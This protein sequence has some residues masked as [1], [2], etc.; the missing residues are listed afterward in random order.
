M[1]VSQAHVVSQQW[2]YSA[3]L[4][5]WEGRIMAMNR[6]QFQPGMS[7]PTFIKLYGTEV[8]CEAA[9]EQARW[10]DGTLWTP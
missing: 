1:K 3:L 6:I 8:K 4:I 10:P 7:M 9:Q 2:P 5:T